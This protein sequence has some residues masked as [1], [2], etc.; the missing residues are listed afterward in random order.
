M[1]DREMERT[2]KYMK[3]HA[4]ENETSSPSVL[5]GQSTLLSKDLGPCSKNYGRDKYFEVIF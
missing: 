4:F 2:V 3:Y 1:K 5:V